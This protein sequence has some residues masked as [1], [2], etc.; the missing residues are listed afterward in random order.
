M[1]KLAV[2]TGSPLGATLG[3]L[4]VQHEADLGNKRVTSATVFR[5]DHAVETKLDI[6]VL[7]NIEDFMPSEHKDIEIPAATL[8]F[9]I[10]V[11][12]ESKN[13]VRV[14]Q[15]TYERGGMQVRSGP[16]AEL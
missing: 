9:D 1:Q 4:L 7:F 14:H 11:R 6:Q 3:F 13:K 2:N 10:Q 12:S 5:D 8:D 16:M 15:V